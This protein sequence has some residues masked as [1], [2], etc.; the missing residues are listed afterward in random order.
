MPS[1]FSAV[2][3]QE[4]LFPPTLQ[5]PV[6]DWTWQPRLQLETLLEISPEWESCQTVAMGTPSRS[7]TSSTWIV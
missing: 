7:W 1:Q 6:H 3:L 2:V 5:V 4:P